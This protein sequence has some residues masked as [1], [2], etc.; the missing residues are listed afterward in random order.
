MKCVKRGERSTFKDEHGWLH[1]NK[2][3]SNDGSSVQ[4]EN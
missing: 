2:N 3:N 1:N 4:A